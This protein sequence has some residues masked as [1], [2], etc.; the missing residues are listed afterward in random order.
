MQIITG[1]R[2]YS[3]REFTDLRQMLEQSSELYGSRTAFRFREKPDSEPQTRTYRDFQNDYQALGTALTALGL[4]DSNIAIVGENSY[5]W[6]VAHAAI[7]GGAGIAVP[8]D[9]LLPVEE[10]VNLIERAEVDAIFYDSIFHN[11]L[12]PA[13][14]MNQR[15]Q[16]IICLRPQLVKGDFARENRLLRFDDLLRQGAE[17]IQS[18]DRS[19]LDS[20]IDPEAIMT[21]LFT[22]GTTSMAKAVMLSHKNVCA[23]I[24]GLAG[25]VSLSPGIR[26]LS[27]LPLHHTFENTCGL[28][29]ALYVGAE[30]CENDGLR[31][32]QK[33][34]QEY[35]INMVIGVPLLFNNFYSKIRETLKK[36]GK[37]KLI[38]SLIRLTEFL[39]RLKI[40]LRKIFY[41]RIIEAFGGCFTMGIC[42]AA[43]ISADVIRFFDAIGVR[44]LEGYG[45]TEAS[46]VIAG[47]NSKVFIPGTVGQPLTGITLA[48]DSE[49]AGETGEIL[50]RGD[51][52]MLGYYKDEAAT[53]EAIDADGWLHTGDLGH[54]DPKTG[55]LTITG[56]LKSM[57]VLKSGKKV[58]P[59]EIE[60]LFGQY[61]SIRESLVWGEEVEGEITVSAKLVLDKE[62]MEEQT[63]RPA[64][65]QNIKQYLE[66]LIAEIN[67]RMPTFKGIRQYVYSFQEMVKTTTRKIRRPIEIGNLSELMARQKLRWKEIAGKNIDDLQKD[68]AD[69]SRE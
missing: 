47:C 29:M 67:S 11:N 10:L 24:K 17:L 3:V 63:G 27:V 64:D 56:R 15:L 35:R 28:Y 49:F 31:Y 62:K 55:C 43:P 26:L 57:I 41:K 25:V 60:Y 48:V 46:P 34:M 53:A 9:R 22:S 68:E 16:H 18:G 50:A 30:I 7:I 37:E 19:W 44:V 65:E 45:L 21:L 20:K 1:K 6:R 61:E 2:H 52:I 38:R 36:T 8:L 51:N 40:D 66:Q 32:I 5:A 59:E 4:K 69:G 14:S 58:F 23:D 33:N 13:L 42:G 12:I 39:R 54:I